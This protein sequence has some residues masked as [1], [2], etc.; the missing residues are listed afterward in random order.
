MGIF[1]QMTEV[2]NRTPVKLNVRFDGQDIEIPP[3]VSK[4]PSVA[5]DYAKNQNPIMGS[6]D[7]NNPFMSGARYLLGIVGRDECTPLTKEE[8][9]SHLGKP[10]RIN[11]DEYMEDRVP[12]GH[13][14][15]VRG[16]G[17]ATQAKSSFD[18]GVRVHA[19]V[20][21]TDHA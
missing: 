12:A 19:P 9:T 13:H 20:V 1:Y 10:A 8:W 15:E 6:A 2:F 11:M 18:A 21:E 5:V 4:I 16:K 14:L 7:A 3:G 17:R